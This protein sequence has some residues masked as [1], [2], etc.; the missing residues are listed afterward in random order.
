MKGEIDY[1]YIPHTCDKCSNEFPEEMVYLFGYWC[2]DGEGST[3]NVG[4][5]RFICSMCLN[6]LKEEYQYTIWENY[7]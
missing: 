4:K 6:K 3:F 5:E 1:G 2:Y 7:D